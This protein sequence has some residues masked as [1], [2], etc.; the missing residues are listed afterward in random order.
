VALQGLEMRLLVLLLVVV[1]WV[2]LLTEFAR[3]LR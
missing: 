1:G 3:H 2:A